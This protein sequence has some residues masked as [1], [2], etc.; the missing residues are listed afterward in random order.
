VLPAHAPL[1]VPPATFAKLMRIPYFYQAYLL[2][3]IAPQDFACH[4]A[5]ITACNEANAAHRRL[6]DHCVRLCAA[7]QP[8]RRSINEILATEYGS[9]A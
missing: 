6:T 5:F 9:V 7:A 4:A 3:S 2:D 1:Q 8:S